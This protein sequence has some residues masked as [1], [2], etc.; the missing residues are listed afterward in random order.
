MFGQENPFSS[1]D[2]AQKLIDRSILVGAKALPLAAIAIGV[3]TAK[4]K[5]DR[6]KRALENSDKISLSAVDRMLKRHNKATGSNVEYSV[7]RGPDNGFYDPVSGNLTFMSRDPDVLRDDGV[8]ESLVKHELG[9]ATDP[10]SAGRRVLDVLDSQLM[11]F[12]R[13][14][15]NKIYKE[16]LR[17]WR[18][19]RKMP[20]EVD[21]N[22]R[23]AALDTY[24]HAIRVNAWASAA[25]IAATTAIVGRIMYNRHKGRPGFSLW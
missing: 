1:K 24:R 8:A 17:A 6:F 10:V 11:P 2:R 20:G 3:A 4:K 14:K 7:M 19:A 22:L 9:H 13:I 5:H 21:E 15:N 18:N 16:E 23:E 25:G 12:R